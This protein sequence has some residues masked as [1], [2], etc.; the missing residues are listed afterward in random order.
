M[1]F[2]YV[3]GIFLVKKDK[4][5]NDKINGKQ[6]YLWQVIIKKFGLKDYFAL[7]ITQKFL[8]DS[9]LSVS[10][11]NNFIENFKLEADEN[12]NYKLIIN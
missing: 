3:I 10:I 12:Y 11:Y 4:D 2:V 5:L 7:F 8:S 9:S 1:F 6:Q